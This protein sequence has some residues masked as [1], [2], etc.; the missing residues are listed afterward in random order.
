M[1][2]A[3]LAEELLLRETLTIERENKLV[4]ETKAFSELCLID[5]KSGLG[6]NYHL[7]SSPPLS[8]RS[9][10]EPAK[11]GGARQNRFSVYQ[12]SCQW[13]MRQV[14]RNESSLEPLLAAVPAMKIL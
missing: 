4:R 7:A 9:P 2:R 6:D 3:R 10:D 13:P 5:M 8:H 14:A 11:L 1:T 12:Q